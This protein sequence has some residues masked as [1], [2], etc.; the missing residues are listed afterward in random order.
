MCLFASFPSRVSP[1]II[2]ILAWVTCPWRSGTEKLEFLGKRGREHLGTCKLDMVQ[3]PQS[4]EAL[5]TEKQETSKER[6]GTM[7][8]RSKEG[9]RRKPRHLTQSGCSIHFEIYMKWKINE[10]TCH[11]LCSFAKGSSQLYLSPLKVL[12]HNLA[13]MGKSKRVMW[14]VFKMG[15][16]QVSI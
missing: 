8:R 4:P 2:H 15:S 12:P 9:G 3:C 5:H 11:I 6:A 16:T 14:P 1:L 10:R 7:Y 13:A